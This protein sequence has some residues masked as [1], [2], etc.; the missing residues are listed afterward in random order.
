MQRI[1]INR[2]QPIMTYILTAINVVVF[3]FDTV[4]QWIW[5]YPILTLYGAKVNVAILFG[6][7]WRLITPIFLHSG[8]EHILFNSL[9]LIIWGRQVET[10]LG[11]WKY[12]A[13]YL[14]AG[15]MGS[16]MS[17]AFSP[18][19]SVGAS[20]AIFGL[21]GALLYFG[22]EHKEIFNRIFGVQ[23]L[24]IIGVNLAM[25]F[26]Q[27]NI[28]NFGHIGGPIGGYLAC[29]I[30]GFYGAAGNRGLRWLFLAGYIAAAAILLTLG[31]LLRKGG[32]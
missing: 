19:A 3:L 21:F 4:S 6:Q 23:L 17:F 9:A 29:G 12:L 15:F 25:G 11:K 30:T 1:T 10:L 8:V 27:P 7:Y 24:I 2:R 32:Y 26:M 18:N 13:V 14:M 31:V 5:G 22:R 20:G 16:C 28:D